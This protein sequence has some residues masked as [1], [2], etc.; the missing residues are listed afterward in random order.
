MRNLEETYLMWHLSI[1]LTKEQFLTK[2]KVVITTTWTS[3]LQNTLWETLLLTLLSP[4]PKQSTPH[5]TICNSVNLPC[6]QMPL[7]SLSVLYQKTLFPPILCLVNLPLNQQVPASP[8]ERPSSLE[9]VLW[10][11]TAYSPCGQFQMGAFL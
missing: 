6:F 11:L 3:I 4:V 1:L 10:L 2:K 8:L 7:V 5:W 9:S